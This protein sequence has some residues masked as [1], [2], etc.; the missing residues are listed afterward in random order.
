MNKELQDYLADQ[1][2]KFQCT[3]GYAPEQNGLAERQNRTLMEAAGTVL[4]DS[5]L[6]KSYWAEAIKHAG[7]VNNR[8]VNKRHGKSPLEMMFGVKPNYN[9]MHP[10]K[11]GWTTKGRRVSLLDMMNYQKDKELQILKV[12]KLVS[13]VMSYIC[14]VN[15]LFQLISLTLLSSLRRS[16]KIMKN[17]Q[18]RMKT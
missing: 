6:P 11:T 13:A 4:A 3:T 15:H 7:F 10:F 16:R 12:T 18:T 2:I 17:L 9:D 8:I 5:E 14:K 1:G